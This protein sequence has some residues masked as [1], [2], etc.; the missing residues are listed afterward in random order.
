MSADPSPEAEAL[1]SPI[2]GLFGGQILEGALFPYPEPSADE[3]ETVS[4]FLDSLRSF[5][6]DRVDPA[7]FDR[8]RRIPPEVVEGLADL[9]I[10]GLTIPEAYGG[11]G[12]SSSAYCRVMEEVGATDASLGILIGGHQSIGMK[13]LLLYGTEEQK[14]RWLPA[15]AT[16]ESIAAFALTEPEAG[17]DAA[18]IRTTARFDAAKD[19]F[20][21]DG[22]KHWISNGG[23][24]GFFTVFAKDVALD[25][26]DEHRRIT[27][28]AVTRDLPG[29]EIGPE[30]KKLGLKGSSTVPLVFK[31]LRVPAA[32]V[33][34]PRGGGFK[35]AVEVLNTGRTSLG[36]GCLG[37]SK[38]M[39]RAAALHA[40]E[41]RQF[42]SRIADFEMIRGKF[43]RMVVNTYAL[44]SVVFLTAGL[45]DR[46]LSDYALEGAACKVFGTETVWSVIND[47]LQI[48]GGNGFMEEYPY[49]RALRDSRVNMIFEGTNEILRV[50]IA[51]SGVRELASDLE[52]VSRALKTPLNSMGVL[53][54]FVGRK[55]RGY[56]A[57][58]RIESVVPELASEADV[59]TR[60]S[61]SF[62]TAAETFVVKYGK[63]LIERQHQQERL[64]NVA[65]DLYVSLAVLSRSSAAVRAIGAERAAHEIRFARAFVQGAKYRIVGELK[66]MDKNRD[67][68]RSAER[69]GLR[70]RI[71]ETAY[72]TP[73]YR[74]DFWV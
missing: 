62:A 39:I 2:K 17:S 21:L 53:S 25:V 7:V 1:A 35:V 33:I 70:N 37:G 24:A 3:R 38:T 58:E 65:I 41:R 14:K 44:E 54:E 20:V 66:E 29:L 56:V 6:K 48:A 16:G 15:L 47:A 26:K 74:L 57:P 49:E 34:G 69:D 64:A 52:E 19:E 13:A 8:E 36:A 10:F 55:I 72:E 32:N 22:T 28:F 5:A 30:E 46:G 61:R 60:Y 11:Y 9:G 12:F 71:A 42:G 27:A 63:T 43:E 73:G 31:D 40:R 23:I 4:A 51:L 45:V 50:L 68:E 67:R 59:V 18:S